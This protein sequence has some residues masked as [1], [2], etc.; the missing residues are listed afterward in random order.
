[1]FDKKGRKFEATWSGDWIGWATG[2]PTARIHLATGI[3]TLMKLSFHVPSSEAG[4]LPTIDSVRFRFNDQWYEI[5]NIKVCSWSEW[6]A[7][8]DRRSLK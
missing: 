6:E 2:G 4:D 3:P 1:M 5:R 7:I 8:R